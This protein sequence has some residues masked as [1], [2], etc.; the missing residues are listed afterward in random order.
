MNPPS[1]FGASTTNGRLKMNASIGSSTAAG[2]ASLK[3]FGASRCVPEWLNRCSSV[4]FELPPPAIELNGSVRAAGG[5]PGQTGEVA[6]S[7]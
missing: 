3:C 6:L 7:G 2:P 5:L 1:G 4:V